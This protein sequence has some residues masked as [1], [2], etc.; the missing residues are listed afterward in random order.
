MWWETD[1]FM[2]WKLISS[3]DRNRCVVLGKD[4]CSLEFSANFICDVMLAWMLHFSQLSKLE[5]KK[6][7]LVLA[8][9]V[10]LSHV[11]ISYKSYSVVKSNLFHL[12]KSHKSISL[13]E[14]AWRFLPWKSHRSMFFL[15]VAWRYYSS[16]SHR[17]IFCPKWFGGITLQIE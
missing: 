13:S 6:S 15:E 4:K 11:T 10:Q 3:C 17:S 7:L 14:V 9:I 2:W 1:F 12:S 16:K 5:E 8:L